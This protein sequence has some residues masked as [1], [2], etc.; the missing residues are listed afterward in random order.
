MKVSYH[1]RLIAYQ[2]VNK[3]I[4]LYS[5]PTADSCI[6]FINRFVFTY[7]QRREEQKIPF[8][9]SEQQ[10]DFIRWLWGLY[11]EKDLSK[12]KGVVDKARDVG[13]T[14]C[15]IA[16][17]VWVFLFLDKSV[18]LYSYKTDAVDMSGNMNSL[19][20]KARFILRNLPTEMTEGVVSKY[21]IISRDEA[22]IS[23]LSGKEPRGGRASFL[24]K[25]ESAFY[26]NA[27]KVEAA[28]SEFADCIVDVSTHSGTT[29]LFFTKTTSGVIPVF[30]FEW[31]DCPWHTQKMYDEKKREAIAKGMEAEF[32][33]E[34][35]RNPM[36]SVDNVVIPN[37]YVMSAKK[38]TEIIPGNRRAGL[39]IADE[40]IDTNALCIMSGN[41][42]EYLE[43][44]AGLDPYETA[45]KAFWI[46]VEHKVEVFQFDSIGLGAATKGIIREIQDPVKT[47][48]KDLEGRVKALEKKNPDNIDIE[49][50]KKRIEM[51]SP[52]A[53]M[54]VRGYNAGGAVN[55]PDQVEYGDKTNKELFE[56]SK[57]QACFKLRTTFLNT[58]K[59]MNG[60]E[61]D[62]NN[63]ISLNKISKTSIFNKFMRELSQPQHKLTKPGRI[64]IDK[65][66]PG[67]KSPNLFDALM[68]CEA[69]IE[70]EWI[71][72]AVL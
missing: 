47:E 13:A 40:G 8:E 55:E 67:T 56:N 1:E 22:S 19:F 50:M 14:W 72:W 49:V 31:L 70:S 58:H 46:C 4:A 24:F 62:K 53:D 33:R 44:W 5:I 26:E 48:K 2:K 42:V 17:S 64:I 35:D 69:Q 21:M 9:L 60:E 39:D 34:I 37:E 20:E 71:S 16:F 66:P 15:F 51:I 68:I 41:E 43:E 10:E 28:L 52:I 25:D 38:C 29:S 7:D 6:D 18:N 23:G 11:L 59:F 12:K 36:A 27:R 45:K 30:V 57:A 61:C 32:A 3:Y 54:K 65:K 63:I